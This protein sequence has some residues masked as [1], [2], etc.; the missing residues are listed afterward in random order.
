MVQAVCRKGITA[1][2]IVFIWVQKRAGMQYCILALCNFWEERLKGSALC[3]ERPKG[4]LV[5]PAGSV[6][7]LFVC[8]WHTAPF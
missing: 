1:G 4:A 3:G 5:S 6:G 7:S 2:I 8:H